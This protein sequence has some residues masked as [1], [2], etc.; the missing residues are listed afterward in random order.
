M[1]LYKTIMKITEKNFLYTM[2][3][4]RQRL[5]KFLKHELAKTHIEGIAPSYGD[6]LFVLDQ[7]GP[8]TMQE[9]A[10]HTIKDK[11][12]ISSVINKLE[13]GGYIVKEKDAG[14][15]RFTNL[16]L[17]PKAV[18]LRPVLFAISEKMN[19]KMFEGLTDAEKG[20]LFELLGKVYRNL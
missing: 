18:A 4:I 17:T 6:I 5:F 14:D 8:I 12:T 2:T 7:E 16:T 1:V 13:A 15:A 3:A 9:L 10:K 11:S 20:M 19:A